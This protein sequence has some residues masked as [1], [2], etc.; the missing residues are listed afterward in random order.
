M[1]N[2]TPDRTEQDRRIEFTRNWISSQQSITM[3][4]RAT[5]ANAADAEDILQEVACQVALKY[6][7]YDS[8]RP[9]LPWAIG[10][11][12]IKIAE[13]YRIRKKDTTVY[14]T[15]LIESLSEACYRLHSYL[16]PYANALE[17]C[18]KKLDSKSARLLALRY[19]E[20]LTPQAIAET[21]NTS[22]GS[23]RVMLTRIRNRLKNC[24]Q[25][26]AR[27]DEARG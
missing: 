17:E 13:Y 26:R 24:M 10:V 9:F 23:V 8:E 7:E 4:I 11:A 19:Q 12:K 27:L 15:D 20:N 14:T 1:E 22:S 6:D 2:K 25:L 18:L 5:I 3:F 16:H 21:M